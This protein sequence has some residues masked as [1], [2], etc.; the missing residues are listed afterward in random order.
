M[1][2][3]TKRCSALLMAVL[4]ILGLCCHMA[5]EARAIALSTFLLGS[6]GGLLLSSVLAANGIVFLD[7]KEQAGIYHLVKFL[8]E[9]VLDWVQTA[10]TNIIVGGT[11]LIYNRVHVPKPVFDSIRDS[12]EDAFPVTQPDAAQTVPYVDTAAL[13]QQYSWGISVAASGAFVPFSSSKN[14]GHGQSITDAGYVIDAHW[15]ERSGGGIEAYTTPFLYITTPAGSKFYMRW[16]V[17]T[18]AGDL[19]YPVVGVLFG[20]N[21]VK[22]LDGITDVAVAYVA[23]VTQS[24]DGYLRE[25]YRTNSVVVSSYN[26]ATDKW[27]DINESGLATL[28]PH[29][30]A[31]YRPGAW[32]HDRIVQTVPLPYT[33]PAENVAYNPA[34]STTFPLDDA[35][36]VDIAVPSDY[37]GTIRKPKD[38][39]VVPDAPLPIPADPA[40]EVPPGI[41]EIP[42]SM[43]PKLLTKFPFSLPWDFIAAIELLA[44]PPKVPR[45]E[46]DFLAPLRSRI[47]GIGNTTIVLDLGEFEGLAAFCRWFSTLGF[48]VALMMLTRKLTGTGG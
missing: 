45:F 12:V 34:T 5:V 16:R 29:V 42:Q 15:T 44:R 28:Y 19:H 21:V 3:V 26:P 46:V 7:E 22:A 47:P 23:H 6:A 40:I 2:M 38:V 1:A 31:N 11:A 39:V 8:G 14:V 27:T 41:P 37:T 35:L 25:C 36:G 20:H 13:G 17:T 9:D 24:S 48:G 10:V 30:E 4:L 33:V 43:R 32:L 18:S